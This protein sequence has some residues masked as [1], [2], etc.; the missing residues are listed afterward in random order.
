M[1][2]ST[3]RALTLETATNEPAT[4]SSR[5]APTQARMHSHGPRAF[6]RMIRSKSSTEASARSPAC[7]TPAVTVTQVGTPQR[8]RVSR[9]ASSMA[10]GSVTSQVTSCAPAMSQVTVVV[11]RARSRSA[12][13]APMPDPPPTTSASGSV[14]SFIGLPSV[15]PSARPYPAGS[16]RLWARGQG[17]PFCDRD[18]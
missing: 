18:A 4:P 15:P 9:T 14:S 1:L 13:A 12:R 7:P 3:S 5:I 8:A 11:P 2:R 17:A 16:D 10:A 6:T